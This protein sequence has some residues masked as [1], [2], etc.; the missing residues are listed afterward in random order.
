MKTT[1]TFNVDTDRLMSLT[2]EYIAA[3]WHLGQ[4]NPAPHGDHDAGVLVEHI[5]R[6]IVRRWLRAAPAPLWN[7]QGTDYPHQQLA[8]FARWNGTDWVEGALAQPTVPEIL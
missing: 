2:D 1:I 3:L 8:R 7:V 4:V 5:S 6:E